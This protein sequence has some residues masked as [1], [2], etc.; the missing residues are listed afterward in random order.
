MSDV[1]INQEQIDEAVQRLNDALVKKPGQMVLQFH[2]KFG[3]PAPTTPKWAHDRQDLRLDLIEEE[4]NEFL[5]EI[6]AEDLPKAVKEACDVVYVMVGWVIEQGVDFDKAFAEVHRSNMSK[7][8]DDGQV[9][10]R[11]DGKVLKPPG[12]S[13]AD[14]EGVIGS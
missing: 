3:M 4:V 5:D 7:V 1:K 2:R 13:P 10:F 14:I 6:E 12:Y 11:E 9:R 8:W